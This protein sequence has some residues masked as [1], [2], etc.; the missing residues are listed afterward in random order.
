VPRIRRRGHQL[1][2]LTDGQWQILQFGLA[3]IPSGAG[4]ATDD[5]QRAAWRQYRDELMRE[6]GPGRRPAAYFQFDLG[7][8]PPGRWWAQLDV[9]LDRD[10]VSREEAAR[11]EAENPALARDASPDASASFESADYAKQF[12][13]HVVRGVME[14]LYLMARWHEWRG[15]PELAAI[16][17]RRAETVRA[18]G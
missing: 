18:E 9:L 11:I 13:D 4:F 16:H 5:E 14:Q 1:R 7:I 10:L 2:N 8:S 15:R 6:I 3:I 12:T 17:R